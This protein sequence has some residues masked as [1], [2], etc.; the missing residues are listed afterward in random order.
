MVDAHLRRRWPAAAST[1]SSPAVSR[2]TPSTSPGSCR[3]SRR[4]ST[5]TRCCSG[6]TPTGGGP[7]GRRSPSGSPRET[8]DFLLRDLGTREGGFA[9]PLD[10]DAAG[11]EGLTYAWTPPAARR[12]PRR[13][14][15]RTRRRPAPRHRRRH[16]RGRLSTLQLPVDPADP[17]LVEPT[18]A[19]RL[20]T[21]RAG[22]PQP[23][24]DDKVVTAWNGLADRRPGRPG[25]DPR[26]A[27]TTSRPR[28]ARRRSSST[29]ISSTAGS[30]VRR[31][32]GRWATPSASL[33]DYG[34]L[35]EGLLA[36]HQATGRAALAGRGGRP[37]RHRAASTSPPTT[38]ASTTP[39]TT[40]SR[41]SPGRRARPTTPSRPGRRRLA[42]ALLTYGA[43]TGSTRHLDAAEA[44]LRRGR[45]RSPRRTRGSPGW[46][47]AV[48]EARAAG[49]LQ[50]AVV[51]SGRR[52]R[53]PW[54]PSPAPR[55]PRDSCSW[56]ANPTR[57]AYPC[58]RTARSWTVGPRPTS[59]G[60]RLR[61]PDHRPRRAASAASGREHLSARS[62]ARERFSRRVATD[63]QGRGPD[64]GP[65]QGV[66]H[67]GHRPD[68]VDRLLRHR[69]ER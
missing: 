69:V 64:V 10:A 20:L 22:R 19:P 55:R 49:P 59:A 62:V 33:D 14:R 43:L 8:A 15:R 17:V 68:A 54:S 44:A 13:R 66:R 58:W 37:P 65:Q 61:P 35:A 57:P 11:V 23:G 12:G 41:S 31:G 26:R 32:T 4:C 38:A 42:G 67:D 39:P 63:E 16:L 24:R 7:P 3:T 6:S 36:L 51:G 2:A 47:L 21:A 5:T 52:S 60:V 30:G 27:P 29:P 28:R 18:S 56:P 45:R 48:A 25:L 34:D 46:A 9:V 53:T 1:T 40:P 50:V